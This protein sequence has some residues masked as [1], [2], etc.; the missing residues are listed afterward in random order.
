MFLP[1]NVRNVRKCKV[2]RS[3]SPKGLQRITKK[4]YTLHY[5]KTINNTLYYIIYIFIN[6]IFY[7]NVRCNIYYISLRATRD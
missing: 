4:S 5:L 1:Q 6:Y 2:S 3:Y 7:I